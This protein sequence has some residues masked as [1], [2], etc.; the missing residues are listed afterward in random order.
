MSLFYTLVSYSLILKNLELAYFFSYEGS[1]DKII[2]SYKAEG[3]TLVHTYVNDGN[4]NNINTGFQGTLRLMDRKLQ[5]QGGSFLHHWSSTG[6]VSSHCNYITF[7]LSAI[8]YMGNFNT[9]AFFDTP[10]KY[11]NTS[12]M[13]GK[14]N[15]AY[16]LS[17]GWSQAGWKLRPVL[18]TSS[19]R[20]RPFISG[21]TSVATP[22][23][24]TAAVTATVP[25][26]M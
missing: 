9:Y 4:F 13:K 24:A 23:T 12:S 5:L 25:R 20:P 26:Y 14:T 2:D 17:A 10:S 3:Q 11:L 16:G 15:P 21:T 1:Y 19:P 8:A 6:N 22:T 18:R 7:H